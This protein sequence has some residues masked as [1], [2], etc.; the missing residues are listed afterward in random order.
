MAGGTVEQVAA[1]LAGS[2]E[3]FQNRGGGTNTG[4]LDALYEDALHRA[5]DPSGQ[6]TYTQA[7]ANG[8]TRTQVAT[9][10][11]SSTEYYQVLVGGFYKQFLL[12]PADSS[13]L[14]GYVMVLQNGARDEQV[15]ASLL[16]SAEY[17]SVRVDS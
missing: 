3:Y 4:F 7:L 13:G 14:N 16:G 9:A 6:A 8:A 12:R 17:A 11:Y 10:I 5:I 15:I 1:A 2:Q